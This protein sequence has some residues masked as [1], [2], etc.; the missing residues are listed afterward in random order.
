MTSDL[1]TLCASP[2]NVAKAMNMRTTERVLIELIRNAKHE[3]FISCYLITYPKISE[4][5][6]QAVEEN[7]VSVD[8]YIGDDKT[9]L[10]RS[11]KC[12]EILEKGGVKVHYLSH[13]NHA[14]VLIA[15]NSLGLIGSANF[16]KAGMNKHMEIG[17][18]IDGAT[19]GNYVDQF[20]RGLYLSVDKYDD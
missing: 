12:L 17:I 1:I 14:K 7:N 3:L 11:K 13:P 10:Q 16:S 5:L 8:V 9:Q 4:M 18:H 2:P 20:K 19:C 6:V 15:D